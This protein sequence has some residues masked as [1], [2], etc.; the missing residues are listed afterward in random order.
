MGDK[1][2]IGMQQGAISAVLFATGTDA[3][4]EISA[5]IT[6]HRPRIYDLLF[7]HGSAPADTVIR[8]EVGQHTASGTG[9]S[10]TPV[11]LDQDAPAASVLVEEEFTVGGTTTDDTQV[12][13]FDLNQRATFRW[14]AAPGGEIVIP[15]T[16]ASGYTINASSAT[17]Q[18]ARCTAHWEE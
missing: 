6:T 1:Y 2:A 5:G 12:L 18:I 15:A 16:A 17:P 8:W 4:G 11:L 13:D 9:A 3:V 7:S 10:I 14:V